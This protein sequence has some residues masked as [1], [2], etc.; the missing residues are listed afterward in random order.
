[1]EKIESEMNVSDN[2]VDLVVDRLQEFPKDVQVLLNIAFCMGAQ[3]D[4]RLL[5]TLDEHKDE[6][7]NTSGIRILAPI[8]LVT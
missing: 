1:M 3:F 5:A 8:E 7:P 2:V 4:S 6:E